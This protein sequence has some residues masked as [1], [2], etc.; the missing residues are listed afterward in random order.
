MMYLNDYDL[1][2]DLSS[3]CISCMT[4]ENFEVI[5][6]KYGVNFWFDYIRYGLVRKAR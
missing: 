4:E 2:C 1:V 6:K 5:S 3:S